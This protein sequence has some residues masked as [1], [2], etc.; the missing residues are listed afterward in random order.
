MGYETVE[1]V[2]IGKYIELILMQLMKNTARETADVRS[3]AG[4]N[5]AIENGRLDRSGGEIEYMGVWG[6]CFSAA[7]IAIAM[8]VMSLMTYCIS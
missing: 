8:L 2:R 1:Q 6:C 7:Q 3:D 4:A 5:P